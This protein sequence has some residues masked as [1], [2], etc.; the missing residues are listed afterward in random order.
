MSTHTEVTQNLNRLARRAVEWGRQVPDESDLVAS[1]LTRLPQLAGRISAGDS[2]AAGALVEALIREINSLIRRSP[3][4]GDFVIEAMADLN[5]L[6]AVGG[7]WGKSEAPPK[8]DESH[9][10]RRTGQGI[11][12]CLRQAQDGE[13]V[14]VETRPE[15]D[16]RDFSIR[17]A[18]YDLAVKSMA[19]VAA[20]AGV[21]FT[22]IHEAYCDLSGDEKASA[23]PLRVLLRFWRSQL[24]PLIKRER[25]H[26][27]VIG[28]A[29]K[30]KRAAK[31]A[32]DALPRC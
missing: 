2:D 17:K 26:Y 30:F 23:Y 7:I 18:E 31:A 9:R 12:Y 29:S 15:S 24:P 21:K 32:W 27:Q 6:G 4:H 28:S 20:G 3:E 5:E 22:T 19:Q 16:G 13:T 14:L 25:A 11:T 10:R 8:T 1:I